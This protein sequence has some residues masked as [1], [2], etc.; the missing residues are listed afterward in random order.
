MKEKCHVFKDRLHASDHE[1]V[2]VDCI[3]RDFILAALLGRLYPGKCSHIIKDFLMSAE[4]WIMFWLAL[5]ESG[6]ANLDELSI[7]FLLC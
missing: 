7:L 5:L 6:K 4:I 3:L 2:T 1:N